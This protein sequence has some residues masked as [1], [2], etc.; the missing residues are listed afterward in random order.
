MKK[1]IKLTSFT[2]L[3]LVFAM[4]NTKQKPESQPTP[5]P[6]ENFDWLLGNWQRTNDEEGKST[7]ENWTKI[8]G[9]H[10]SGLGY[11]MQANDTLSQEK[12]DIVSQNGLWTLSVKLPSIPQPIQFNFTNFDETSFTCTNEENDFPKVIK[13]WIEGKDLKAV[14]SGDS[15]EIVFE[16]MKSE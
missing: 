5:A 9:D 16:F 7:F 1:T 14:I 12:M 15:L 8:N 3:L 2:F 10:Y 11:T 13:Y 6:T 4:C